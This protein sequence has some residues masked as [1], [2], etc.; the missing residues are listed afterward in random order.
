MALLGQS[1]CKLVLP[2]LVVYFDPYLSN[3]VQEL[4]APDL[5][6][7]KNP[8]ILPEEISDANWVLISHDHIDH[9]D[10]HTLPKLATASPQSRFMGPQPVLKQLHDW[11]ILSGRLVLAQEHWQ[12]IAPDIRLR[13]VPAAHPV[14][15]RDDEG[16]LAA[17]GYLLDYNGRRLYFAGDTS[18]QQELIEL[19]LEHGPI[20]STVL[21]VNECN[22]F[23]S[24]RGILGN[25]SIREAFLFAQE[26]G[27][28]QVIPVH[29][30]MFAQNSVSPDEIRTVYAQMQPSFEL[31]L[32]PETI[33]L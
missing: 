19:L 27:V 21:P 3:S 23:K 29:W 31:I 25:M 16:Q 26:L 32:Q 9:C 10:P 6:R 5:T 20:H 1:G 18:V 24:R 2:G 13:A 33:E 4:D 12:S 7:L 15:Q 22:F 28:Q 17:V 30:D 11:G 8:P 14:I